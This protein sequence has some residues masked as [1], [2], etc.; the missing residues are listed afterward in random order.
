MLKFM[1]YSAGLINLFLKK[2]KGSF[3]FSPFTPLE[4]PTVISAGMMVSEH[5]V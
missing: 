2:C 1:A 3:I 4:S 5:G